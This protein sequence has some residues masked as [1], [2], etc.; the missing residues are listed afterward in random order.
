MKDLSKTSPLWQF[1][2]RTVSAF[3]SHFLP[4]KL[5]PSLG[6]FWPEP[7]GT[8]YVFACHSLLDIALA[9]ASLRKAG[10][11]DPL[12]KRPQ[13]GLRAISL[14]SHKGDIRS[15]PS[16]AL[17]AS[18]EKLAETETK[19]MLFFPIWSRMPQSLR[20]VGKRQL[21]IRSEGSRYFYAIWNRGGHY[22][23]RSKSFD[24][25]RIILRFLP[26]EARQQRLLTRA[27][28]LQLRAWIQTASG[29]IRRGRQE[30][31][32]QLMRSSAVLALLEEE[33]RMTGQTPRAVS[34]K[35]KEILWRMA[36][37]LS[38]RCIRWS[39]GLLGVVF[40]RLYR[41]ISFY[42]VEKIR[43]LADRGIQILYLPTHRSHFDY[44]LLSYALYREGVALPH[45]A[46]G[47][48]LDF[49]PVGAPFRKGGAFFIR[50]R[51]HGNRFYTG[52]FRAYFMQLLAS[53][54]SIEWFLE[55]GRS[56]TG[57]ILEP[58]T[59]LVNLVA[60]ALRSSHPHPV[61]FVPVFF[62]Y[63]KIIDIR[64]Y[65]A[66]AAGRSKTPE[67]HRS[68]LQ[69]VR[70]L[71]AQ[72]EC[73]I[74]V[75]EPISLS[76]LPSADTWS[77]RALCRGERWIAESI[78]VFA[79]RLAEE[80][81]FAAAPT[82]VGLVMVAMVCT[83][84]AEIEAQPLLVRLAVYRRLVET[85]RT[86]R[87][88]E[89]SGLIGEPA[90]WIAQAQAIGLI[91]QATVG[92]GST[93]YRCVVTEIS[94]GRYT[95]NTLLPLFFTQAFFSGIQLRQPGIEFAKAQELLRLALTPMNAELRM[96]PVCL[97]ESYL[98]R[99]WMATL[100]ETSLSSREGLSLKRFL[101]TEYLRDYLIAIER[102]LADVPGPH[103][104]V[105]SRRKVIDKKR[106]DL[107]RKRL[108][109]CGY[110]ETAPE[111]LSATGKRFLNLLLVLIEEQPALALFPFLS[112]EAS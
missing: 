18:L 10:W 19:G 45:I 54:S 8:V 43:R 51:F 91:V 88:E 73:V 94:M 25:N 29:P 35:A 108:T 98:R 59:G 15:A 52:L 107:L 27:V 103:S 9:R 37:D 47:S 56:R 84:Q 76:P 63:D 36:A 112:E 55:G 101:I 28:M 1:W 5:I 30:Q 53:G 3:F 89:N 14:L 64:S 105:S 77:L 31:V 100:E 85:E 62:G 67:S 7:Q 82:G 95:L 57:F 11:P 2:C 79:K 92:E 110:L 78:Q 104:A 49:W 13:E 41:Q 4:N 68:L 109:A 60:E 70:Q 69:A 83:D 12:S 75:G 50:R 33:V 74:N 61:A 23:R 96:S 26:F 93:C 16:A 80:M 99:C 90:L 40:K 21:V 48:N 42:G 20:Q 34:A 111:L 87:G 17:L 72:G 22:L 38:P 39:D 106:S 32:D 6:P 65:E 58:K 66:E 81:N 86:F 97:T 71:K 24:L 102:H 46:A 44:L